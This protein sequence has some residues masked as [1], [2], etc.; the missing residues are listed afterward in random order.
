MVN[1][2]L[3]SGPPPGDQGEIQPSESTTDTL[4]ASNKTLRC[5]E[6]QPPA[7]GP[8]P[9]T[10]YAALACRGALIWSRAAIQTQFENTT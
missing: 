9:A 4:I 1:A 6:L 7:A 2:G 8:G 10:G 3:T 5:F